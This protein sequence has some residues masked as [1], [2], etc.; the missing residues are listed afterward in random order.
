MKAMRAIATGICM[1]SAMALG[2]AALAAATANP[3]PVGQGSPNASCDWAIRIDLPSRMG[4]KSGAT[5]VFLKADASGQ[6]QYKQGAP[7]GSDVKP[8]SIR[9]SR[10]ATELLRSAA[11]AYIKDPAPFLYADTDVCDGT[12]IYIKVRSLSESRI[13]LIANAPL[14]HHVVQLRQVILKAL[15]VSPVD[16]QEKEGVRETLRQLLESGLPS[17]PPD[18]LT[19]IA[20]GPPDVVLARVIVD[21]ASPEK[22]LYLTQCLYMLSE[23]EGGITGLKVLAVLRSRPRYDENTRLQIMWISI[24]GGCTEAMS[25]YPK[26]L[27]AVVRAQGDDWQVRHLSE[28]ERSVQDLLEADALRDVLRRVG[29]ATLTPSNAETVW[30]WLTANRAD[31]EYNTSARKYILK[32]SQNSSR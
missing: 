2:G 24:E 19:S 15:S 17:S 31:L 29:A 4:D 16:E 1:I 8:S 21:L 13:A 27:R 32:S 30:T 5:A 7:K 11:S 28:L 26:A 25:E 20:N 12:R 14:P 22:S 9:L 23:I 3:R 10:E 6:L 18:D